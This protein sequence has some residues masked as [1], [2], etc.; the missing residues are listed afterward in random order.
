MI[1]GQVLPDIRLSETLK[2]HVRK[3]EA[4]RHEAKNHS[5]ILD[6][7]DEPIDTNAVSSMD[8]PESRRPSFV[9][10][11]DDGLVILSHNHLGGGV[12]DTNH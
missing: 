2:E 3:L 5:C 10:D 7:I 6:D 8:M 11:L 1:L 4:R 12:S 9:E